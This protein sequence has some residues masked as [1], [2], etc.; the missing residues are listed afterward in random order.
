MWGTEKICLEKIEW[1]LTIRDDETGDQQQGPI[2][3]RNEQ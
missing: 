3:V 1:P 2:K